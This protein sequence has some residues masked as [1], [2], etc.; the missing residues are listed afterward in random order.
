MVP[1]VFCACTET[2]AW[3]DPVFK[4]R[5]ESEMAAS[6]LREIF[7]AVILLD[8]SWLT[9]TPP[10]LSCSILTTQQVAHLQFRDR[11]EEHLHTVYL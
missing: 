2:A 10:V 11:G 8:G 4:T 7:T 9:E 6:R 3:P 1:L 5:A